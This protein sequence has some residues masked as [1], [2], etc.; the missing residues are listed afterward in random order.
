VEEEGR[1]AHIYL[2]HNLYL[3]RKQRMTL[4]SIAAVVESDSSD[5]RA[6]SLP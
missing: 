2:H 1:K 4:E 6:N 5:L 3:L